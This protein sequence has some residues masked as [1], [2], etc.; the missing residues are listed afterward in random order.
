MTNQPG[1]MSG[2]VGYLGILLTFATVI[3]YLGILLTF[4]T[5]IGSALV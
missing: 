3:G 5:V 4:A 1:T 2:F